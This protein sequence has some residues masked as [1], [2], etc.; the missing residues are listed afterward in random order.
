MT[1]APPT[2]PPDGND[3]TVR[4]MLLQFT[5]GQNDWQESPKTMRKSAWAPYNRVSVYG[6]RVIK[7][8]EHHSFRLADF[9]PLPQ[10]GDQEADLEEIDVQWRSLNAPRHLP[11]GLESD[12]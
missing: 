3:N 2:D 7:R 1:V 12:G 6:W 10:G 5:E 11:V 9:V 4:T 8:L